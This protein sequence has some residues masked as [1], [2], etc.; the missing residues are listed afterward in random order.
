MWSASPISTNREFTRVVLIVKAAEMLGFVDTPLHMVALTATGKHFV[1]ASPEERKTLW[2]EQLLKLSLFREVYEV[3]QRQADHSVD[4]DF[5]LETIVTRMPYENYEKVFATFVRWGRFGELFVY[6]EVSHRLSLSDLTRFGRA[7]SAAS[8]PAVPRFP[9]FGVFCRPN[10]PA[11]P[12]EI[13]MTR[14][15]ATLFLVGMC[16]SRALATADDKPKDK[17]AVKVE[18]RRAE[19]KAARGTHRGDSGG[20]QREQSLP[21]QD[22]QTSPTTTSPKSKRPKTPRNSRASRSPSPKTAPPK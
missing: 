1:A 21:T 18:F 17:S 22:G 2:R 14:F 10:F 8:V 7:A 6:D 5:V 3:L 20:Q 12:K 19:K 15:T 16:L 4:S 11:A 9:A 13:D